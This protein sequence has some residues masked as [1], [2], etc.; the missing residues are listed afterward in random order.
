MEVY[1]RVPKA[2]K[3]VTFGERRFSVVAPMEWNRLPLDIRTSTSV[4]AFKKKLKTFLF[5]K[6]YSD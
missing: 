3:R 5:T 1:F 2:S 4:D 6:A